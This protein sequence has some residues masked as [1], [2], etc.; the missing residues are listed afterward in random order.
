MEENCVLLGS[1][2]LAVE[3]VPHLRFDLIRRKLRSAV[4]PGGAT[5]T[6]HF[7][8]RNRAGHGDIK[9]LDHTHHRDDQTAVSLLACFI[10]DASLLVAEDERDRSGQ[11]EGE[12][13]TGIRIEMSRVDGEALPPELIIGGVN[14][15]MIAHIEPFHC[16]GRTQSAQRWRLFDGIH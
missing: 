11:I 1:P 14:I 10:R 3:P 12:Q 6:Q 16:A 15:R 13:V 8:E 4:L 5:L 9:A 2:M 7:I